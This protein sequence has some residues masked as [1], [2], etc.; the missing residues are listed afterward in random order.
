MDTSKQPSALAIPPPLC[1]G[2]AQT[3]RRPLKDVLDEA[4]S[5]GFRHFDFADN[6][7][8]HHPQYVEHVRH[9]V[10]AHNRHTWT[11]TWKT[12]T[13]TVAH[14]KSLL[15]ELGCEY[16]DIL[17]THHGCTEAEM[18][19]LADCKQQGLTRL[20]G[21]SNIYDVDFL[22]KH[23]DAIQVNQV[24]AQHID[25][26]SLGERGPALR[27]CI[28]NGIML[29]LYAP[30]SGILDGL[31]TNKVDTVQYQSPQHV[32]TWYKQHWP[33]PHILVVGTVTGESMSVNVAGAAGELPPRM[34][35]FM[36]TVQLTPMNGS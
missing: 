33:P 28:D 12:S 7:A 16:F 19:I 27:A 34:S 31:F 18:V 23:G 5:V 4:Y 32:A 10:Q 35:D 2:T 22:S 29:M 15:T 11:M 17:M 21:V 9:F 26:T 6:Y 36:S 24:Q 14:V 1:L 20:V 25:N 3:T 30:V 8:H 13:M